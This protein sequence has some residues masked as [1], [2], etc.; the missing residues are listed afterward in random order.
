MR[1]SKHRNVIDHTPPVSRPRSTSAGAR[2]DEKAKLGTKACLT[3]PPFFRFSA[4]QL[5]AHGAPAVGS[6]TRQPVGRQ[7]RRGTRAEAAR[8]GDSDT[9]CAAAGQRPTRAARAS[10]SDDS[11]APTG[12]GPDRTRISLVSPHS[13]PLSPA[14]LPPRL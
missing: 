4:E 10:K 11:A 5:P 9:W 7:D 8:A 12:P 14:P 13:L 2:A 6:L 1:W 3:S